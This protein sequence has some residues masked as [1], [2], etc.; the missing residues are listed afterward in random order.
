MR[1]PLL[2]ND[3]IDRCLKDQFYVARGVVEFET[4][5]YP[6]EVSISSKGN[7]TLF[8]GPYWIGIYDAHED[9]T[10]YRPP[11]LVVDEIRN[12]RGQ[13]IRLEI[14]GTQLILDE[15]DASVLSTRSISVRCKADASGALVLLGD[16]HGIAQRAPDR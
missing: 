8:I 7:G 3:E 1:R 13:C 10:L 9:Q 14:S 16:E 11:L 6:Y 2:A 5:C 4:R 15:V 12:R